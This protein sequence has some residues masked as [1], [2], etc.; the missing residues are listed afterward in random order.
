[1]FR[2]S[3]SR[4]Q[5]LPRDTIRTFI[6]SFDTVLTDCDGVVWFL[7][8]AIQGA[9]NVINRFLDMGKRVFFVT[10]SSARTREEFLEKAH[11]LNFN[12]T[13]DGIISSAYMTAQYLR[14]HKF[15]KTAYV[16]GS[17]GLGKELSTFRIKHIG[18][19]PEVMQH[20]LQTFAQEHLKLHRDIGAV[21]IGFDE[22]FSLPKI[23]HACSY[24][25][26][27]ECLFVATNTDER[28]PLPHCV[29]PGT[30]SIVRCVETAAERKA[31]VVGKPN[32]FMCETL[33]REHG[34]DPKRTLMIGDRCNTDILLGANCGFQT[35]LVETGI[36]KEADVQA[37]LKSSDPEERK[38]V[39][40]FIVRVIWLFNDALEGA[41]NVIN[42]FLEMGKKVFF[43]TNNSTKTRDEFLVKARQLNFNIPR[44]GIISTAYLVAQYLKTQNFTKTAYVVGSTGVAQELDAVGIKNIGIGPDVLQNGL[45]SFVNEELKPDPNVGAVVVG[46]DEHFSFPK[47]IRACS[48]ADNPECLFVAT[49]TDERFPLPH[50][51]IPGTGSI[52]RC[53]ET[54]AERKAFVV[55]K[56]NPFMC[57]T[58]IREHGVD[59]KRTLMI[60]DSYVDDP[61]CLFV[62]TNTDERFSLPH[63]VIPGTGSIVRCV[64]TAAERKAFVVGKP[65]PFMCETLI[66]EHGVDPKRTLM[67]GDRCNTDILLGANCGFQTLLVETGIHKEADVQAWLKSSDPEERKLVPDFIVSKL[68][69]LLDYLN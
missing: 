9:P 43:V 17:R 62:A 67:I 55:G 3:A 56:P 14:D 29:I 4:L 24:V 6:N 10:N 38:L 27:P 19:G 12:M 2:Q 68:G 13:L 53:V 48:Y 32:P 42:R 31:F 50:C 11:Q 60:G 49:N 23:I 44:D 54:A 25:D 59:P 51:V 37:W 69:D 30:G 52:V 63:C 22:H 35:L 15:T 41:P 34:V 39:P 36:H 7:N 45:A 18:I 5:N 46:F 65:N 61:E 40:D 21:V 26:D 57:E 16:I 66:R 20:G 8:K 47:L 64:E 1:M 33:I 28:F 58:L